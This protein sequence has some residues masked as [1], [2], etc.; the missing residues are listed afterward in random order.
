MMQ[1]NFA[2]SP[3][4]PALFL[5]HGSPMNAL[6]DNAYTRMLS[7]L[8]QRI[9]KPQAVL[10][11]SA[12]WITQ[13][14]T[15]THM[16]KPKTIHDFGGFPPDLFAIEYPAP[17]SPQ[18]AELVQHTLADSV[19]ALDDHAW[20]LDHGTWSVLRHMYPEADV[21]VV[22]LSLDLS[23]SALDHFRLGQSLR[24]LRNHGVLIVGSGNI[25][26][27]LRTIDWSA[28]AVPFAWGLEFDNWVKTQIEVRNY[29]ALC[30]DRWESESARLSVPT[31]EHFLPLLYVLGA[32]NDED[33]A[34][35]E[36]EGF[37]HASIS[38]RCLS[39]GLAA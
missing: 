17:A 29:S 14:T 1:L 18:L 7:K 26:H 31:S 24:T 22:Q 23:A 37:E 2:A 10:C 38:M 8:G 13:G 21:P 19:I 35:F 4:M 33:Q 12:H 30:V 5:G 25:V 39:F 36:Y 9:Q 34:H 16:V 20:G 28:T 15:V 27:N 6:A 3:R 32:A 11:V